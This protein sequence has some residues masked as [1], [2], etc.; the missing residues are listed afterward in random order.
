[1]ADHR[2]ALVL[3]ASIVGAVLVVI[4]V[5]REVSNFDSDSIAV[6]GPQGNVVDHHFGKGQKIAL[7]TYGANGVYVGLIPNC[8]VT[9]PRRCG[10]GKNVTSSVTVN[11]RSRIRSPPTS[12][13]NPGPTASPVIPRA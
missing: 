12:S 13:P 5:V 10:Q 8:A 7:Y 6:S 4:G 1:M 3:V 9:D 11:Q 2:G